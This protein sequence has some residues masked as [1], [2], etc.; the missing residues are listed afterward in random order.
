MYVYYNILY[1]NCIHDESIYTFLLFIQIINLNKK[2][3][4][5]INFENLY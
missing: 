1:L 5:Y 2:I 4:L 3:F